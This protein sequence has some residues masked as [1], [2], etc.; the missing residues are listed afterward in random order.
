MI[1]QSVVLSQSHVDYV[2]RL[3]VASGLTGSMTAPETQ[4]MYC[5]EFVAMLS[6][7]SEIK[8]V[9]LTRHQRHKGMC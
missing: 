9:L 6:L 3:A 8:M 5:N 1:I 2:Y 7:R 4:G